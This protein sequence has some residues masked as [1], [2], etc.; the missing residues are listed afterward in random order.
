MESTEYMPTLRLRYTVKREAG[1]S[2]ERFSFCRPLDSF[3]LLATEVQPQE[4]EISCF[5]L[6]FE[7][8]S[9]S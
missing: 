7:A 2:K 3:A 5:L 6:I 4:L 9:S 8:R 1:Q